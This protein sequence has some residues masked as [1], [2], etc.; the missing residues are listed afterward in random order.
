VLVALERV[1]PEPA[2]YTHVTYGAAGLELIDLVIEIDVASIIGFL[3][4]VVRDK[5]ALRVAW[6]NRNMS[7]CLQAVGKDIET[8]SQDVVH[9]SVWGRLV[10]WCSLDD[11]LSEDAKITATSTAVGLV[12]NWTQS[13]DLASHTLFYLIFTALRTFTASGTKPF[14]LHLFHIGVQELRTRFR[15]E[16][17]LLHLQMGLSC[18]KSGIPGDAIWWFSVAAGLSCESS[19]YALSIKGVA[20]YNLAMCC[21]RQG[22]VIERLRDFVSQNPQVEFHP[23]I[24]KLLC[25]I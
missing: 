7:G 3:I 12:K 13:N 25:N 10:A 22:A 2:L 8:V 14:A 6:L 5:D 24:S 17:V 1:R 4:A 16:T 9:L 15:L 21:E 18:A 23:K 11:S 19:A 20:L